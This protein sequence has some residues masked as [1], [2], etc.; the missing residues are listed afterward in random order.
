MPIPRNSRCTARPR[1]KSKFDVGG[2]KSRGGYLGIRP[3]AATADHSL[4]E[5]CPI[6]RQTAPIHLVHLQFAGRRKRR[7]QVAPRPFLQRGIRTME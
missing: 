3:N 2:R 6:T 5:G 4:R 7:A 1:Y